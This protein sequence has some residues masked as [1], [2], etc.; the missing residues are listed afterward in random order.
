MEI[1]SNSSADD[2]TCIR[3]RIERTSI[4]RTNGRQT[5]VE[6]V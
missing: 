5:H 4:A 6:E 2:A 3:V 1:N